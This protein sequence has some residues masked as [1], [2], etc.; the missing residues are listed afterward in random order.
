MPVDGLSLPDSCVSSVLTLQ[1]WKIEID[2]NHKQGA[3]VEL[4]ISAS[5]LL[6]MAYRG[7]N[8]EEYDSTGISYD[9]QLYFTHFQ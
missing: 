2:K 5:A 6:S 4:I 8:R 7:H 9:A 1:G 3:I